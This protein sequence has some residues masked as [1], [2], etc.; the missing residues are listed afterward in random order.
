[1]R[2]ITLEETAAFVYI[3]PTYLCRI[4]KEKTGENFSSYLNRIRI[5]AAKQYLLGDTVSLTEIS[6]MTG[7]QDQS[8]FSKV[9]KRVTGKTPWEFKKQRGISSHFKE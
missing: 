2:K 8:Y 5:S 7:F 4:F 9:F 1:M 3:S 6:T